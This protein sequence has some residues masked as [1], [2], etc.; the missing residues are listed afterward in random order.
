MRLQGA[1]WLLAGLAL[2][3]S[4]AGGL[5]QGTFQNL[6]FESANVPVVP[7]SQPVQVLTSD[8]LPWWT[9]YAGPYQQSQVGYNGVSAGGT[10]VSIIDLHTQGFNNRVIGGNFTV[11]LDSGTFFVNGNQ[12]IVASAAIAQSGT[13]P[14]GTRSLM[15][16]ASGGVSE[17]VVTLGGQGLPF[18][19]LSSGANFTTYGADISAFVGQT[20][21]LRFTE[22]PNAAPDIFKIA[23]LDDIQFS[24]TSVP[25]PGVFG[26]F[27]LGALLLGWR[28][29]GRRR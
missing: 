4:V 5:G 22:Q 17:L 8:A 24:P 12:Q 25:E 19:A 1:A 7:S 26:L 16:D 27:T 11:T 18:G 2:L 10:L 13:I 28:V 9:V 23:F 29:L 3:L 21:E 15:F 6:D 14:V 20:A